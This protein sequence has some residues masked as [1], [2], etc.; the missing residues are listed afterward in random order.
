MAS[1]HLPSL[2]R[3]KRLLLIP[4][5]AGMTILLTIFVLAESWREQEAV[6]AAREKTIAAVNEAFEV[7]I[8]RDSDKL[9]T[10]L[11]VIARNDALREA[12]MRGDRTA[13]YNRTAGLFAE[14]RRDHD[15]THFYFIDEDRR[16]FLRVQRPDSYG[17][18]VDRTTLLRAK[19]TGQIAEGLELGQKGVFTL[20]VVEPWRENSGRVAGYIELGMEIDRTL[21]QLHE[22]TGV[23]LFLLVDKR[24]LD[25]R[26]WEEG[27]DMIQQ[28][29]NWDLLPS[30][31]VAG[32]TKNATDALLKAHPHIETENHALDGRHRVRSGN[33]SLEFVSL[34]LR[35]AAGREVGTILLAHDLT[36]M[37]ARQEGF[38]IIVIGAALVVGAAV[39]AL[40]NRAIESM[41]EHL[42]VDERDESGRLHPRTELDS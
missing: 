15:I 30:H 37:D 13:L 39:I 10:A 17:D 6:E 42:T 38:L 1:P 16:M 18:T 4:L 2:A 27:M 35:D 33:R 25:R 9:G 31:V 5:A 20:R 32:R 28:A 34:P 24:H 26:Q 41:Y 19:Q 36:A 22:L 8:H 14:L 29:K 3:C 12:F 23:D 7:A 21:V 40:G 11:A